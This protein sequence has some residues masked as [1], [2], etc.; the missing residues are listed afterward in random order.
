MRMYGSRVADSIH[1]YRAGAVPKATFTHMKY[2]DSVIPDMKLEQYTRDEL[3]SQFKHLTSFPL[4][5][6]QF[7]TMD[8]SCQSILGIIL[9]N[10]IVSHVIQIQKRK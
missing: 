8:P 3:I 2:G 7:D 5:M 9:P 4:V 6:K 10:D 1:D